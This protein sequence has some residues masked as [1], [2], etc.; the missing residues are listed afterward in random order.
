MNEFKEFLEK[1][2]VVFEKINQ[3]Y[4]ETKK[5]IE[6]NDE[7]HYVIMQNAGIDKMKYNKGNNLLY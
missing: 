4:N 7:L 2:P 5:K 1:N 6:I 3:Q